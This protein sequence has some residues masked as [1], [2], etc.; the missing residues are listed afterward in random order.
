MAQKRLDLNLLPI[1]IALYDERSVG[2][3]AIKLGISQPAVSAA[4]ARLRTSLGDPLFVR[5]SKG[6]DPTARTI[7]FIGTAR[8]VIRRI[9]RDLIAPRTFIPETYDGTFTLALSDVGEMVF[10]PRV[11]NQIQTLTPFA[12]LRSVTLPPEELRRSLETGEIDLAV[13][14]FPDIEKGSFFQQR[15]FTHHFTCLLR[16]DHPISG[17]R[18]SLKQFLSL[19]HVAVRTEGRSQELFERFLVARR[20]QRRIVL[21]T[22]H[23]MSLPMII[24]KS[25]L[26][27]TVP[28]AI[29]I[30]YSSAIANIRTVAPPPL[31]LPQIV[32]K[33][34]WHRKSHHDPRS[35]WLRKLVSGLFSQDSDEWKTTLS[36]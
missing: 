25:D 15:L 6:M 27:A 29:G 10:L 22:P 34:H 26:V 11:L 30:Y 23:F 28:H 14:Y 21:Y 12:T 8:D 5:T 2:K 24:A 16:A 31:N 9:E 32:L 7:A 20:I 4:L 17:S 33:Q 35:R 3:A 13:G 18:L 19:G 36:A 1:A